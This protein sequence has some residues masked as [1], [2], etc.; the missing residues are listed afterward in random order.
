[1]QL[2]S[3]KSASTRA[4]ASRP[5][6]S[7]MSGWS[8]RNSSAPASASASPG[9]T[10]TPVR[11]STT[12]LATAPTSLATTGPPARHRLEHDVREPVA[13]ARGVGDRRHDDDVR[14]RVLGRQVGVRARADELD[15]V[16]EAVLR[17]HGLDR[18]TLGALADDPK[19][20]RGEQ[21]GRGPDQDREALLRHEPPDGEDREDLGRRRRA[22]AEA[23]EVDAVGD[24]LDGRAGALEVAGD[25]G[26]AGDHARRVAGALGQAAAAHLARVDRVDAEAVR[27]AQAARGLRG[28]LG[29]Q[30]AK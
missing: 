9:G 28:D 1:M 20:E 11:P 3:S 23:R 14:G 5:R 4:R 15:A 30:C 10:R 29:R 19:P 8:T 6:R 26:V 24:E 18:R 17:D 12:A 13:V 2:S 22:R 25:V 27:D 21:P 7:R 16:A